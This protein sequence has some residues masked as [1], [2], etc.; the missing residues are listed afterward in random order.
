VPNTLDTVAYSGIKEVGKR[1]RQSSLPEFPAFRTR[2]VFVLERREW[3]LQYTLLTEAELAV[4]IGVVVA[5]RGI[6]TTLTVDG[7]LVNVWC[8]EDKVTAERDGVTYQASLLAREA[9]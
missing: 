9:F 1:G 4:V 7:V 5:A 8:P 6:T 2:D 3:L